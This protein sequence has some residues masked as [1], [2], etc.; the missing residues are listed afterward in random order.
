MDDNDIRAAVV[1]TLKSI[2]PEV[3][4][5]ELDPDKPLRSQVD[6]DSMDYLN[7]LV[8]L[9]QRLGVDIPETDYGKLD[10]LNSIVS[11]LAAKQA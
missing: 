3:D 8:G 11:Y 5:R 6:L 1:A 10:T 2:A 7:L 9:H 4:V